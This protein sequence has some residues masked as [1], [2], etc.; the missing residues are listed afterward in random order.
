MQTYRRIRRSI[1][2]LLLVSYLP[3]CYHFVTPKGITPEAYIAAEQPGQVRVTL[4]DGT[5]QTLLRPAL[6]QDSLRGH[7]PVRLSN[8]R[9]RSGPPWAVPIDSVQRLEVRKPN[10]WAT[11][12]LVV[13][14]VVV[15]GAAVGL[16]IF[17]AQFSGFS[18]TS[19][20]LWG[21]Y[22]VPGSGG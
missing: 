1:A 9:V 14:G 17:D 21:S 15:V 3:A 8:N 12:G 4:P 18:F 11:V 13:G 20:P 7:I 16:A 5:R 2:V 22:R 19:D 10:T 6:S